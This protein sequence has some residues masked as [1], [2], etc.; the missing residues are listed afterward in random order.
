MSHRSVKVAIIGAGTA[1]LSALREAR[2]VTDE[3]LLIEGGRFGTTCARVG[4]MPSK[5]LVAAADAAEAVRRADAFGIRCAAPHVDGAA[6]MSRLH[7]LRDGF[8]EHVVEGVERLPDEMVLRGEARFES[9]RRLR[10]DGPGQTVTV[11]AERIVIATGSRST[12]PQEF[13]NLEHAVV[14]DDVFSWQDL[15]ESVAVFGAGV[16]GLELGQALARLGVRVR[17]FGKDGSV[18]PLTDPA[19]LGAARDHFARTLDFV[20]HF[21]LT[22]VSEGAGSVT[23]DYRADGRDYSGSFERLLVAVGRTPNVESLGLSATSLRLDEAG[24]PV[25]DRATGRCGASTVFI[26]GDA[27]DERPLLHEA[28]ELGA[29]AGANAASFPDVAPERRSVPL[30]VVF[31]APQIAMVG[32]TRAA[33]AEEGADYCVGELDWTR[34]GRARVMDEAVGRLHIYAERGTG[35]LLGAEMVGPRSEHLAHLLALAVEREMTG[36]ELMEMPIYHPTFEEGLK[37][38]VCAA[39]SH[40]HT[41]AGAPHHKM[42]PT[43]GG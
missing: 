34:Q 2:Q 18:G 16:I 33:L 22:D 23:V 26:A 21:E 38:A 41:E 12:M 27:A 30:T 37:T 28:A 36:A 20:P 10:V 32:R 24:V 25:F 43:P 15:P 6:V 14:S 9:D 42:G 5:L 19:V 17:L 4:C 11:D 40:S 31:S 8:V 3:V 7:R 35:R 1:G 39:I 29:I 13:A